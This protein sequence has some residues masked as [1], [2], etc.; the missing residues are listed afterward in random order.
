ML[1]IS[2]SKT[3]SKF[4]K[5]CKEIKSGNHEILKL[6]DTNETEFG[7]ASFEQLMSNEADVLAGV[8]KVQFRFDVNYFGVFT[9]ALIKTHDNEDI[10]YILYAKT[11]DKQ[12]IKSIYSTLVKVFGKGIHDER[13]FQT[14]N[15]ESIDSL[16]SIHPDPY[17]F[18]IVN[19]WIHEN[20][21]ILLQYKISPLHQFSIMITKISPKQIDSSIKRKGTILDVLNFD[22]DMLLLQDDIGRNEEFENERVKFVDYVFMTSEKIMGVFDTISVRIFSPIRKFNKN[23]QTHITIYSSSPLSYMEKISTAEKIIR[24]YGQDSIGN[25]ELELYERDILEEGVFWNG[26]TYRLN[27]QHSLQKEKE[28]VIYEVAICDPADSD[29]FNIHIFCY[30]QLIDYFGIS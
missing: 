3:D 10:K 25:N 27:E 19:V 5:F 1:G 9:D 13:R 14:F 30:N 21:T 26:R 29:G 11:R 16:C 6:L 18:D 20:I 24:I 17:S 22:V 28:K 4:E 2:I 12:N 15:E 7:V 8:N 23:V